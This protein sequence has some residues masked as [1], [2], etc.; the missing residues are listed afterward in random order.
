MELLPNSQL[1][2]SVAQKCSAL[3]TDCTGK[4]FCCYVLSVIV[5]YMV[6]GGSRAEAPVMMTVTIGFVGLDFA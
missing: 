2:T 5:L 3:A 4:K 1:F 6:A